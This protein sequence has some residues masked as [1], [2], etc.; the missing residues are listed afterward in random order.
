MTSY[1]KQAS[2]EC[3]QYA[4]LNENHL[5]SRNKMIQ[6]VCEIVFQTLCVDWW[7]GQ[8]QKLRW[9]ADEYVSEA[10]SVPPYYDARRFNHQE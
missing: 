1:N 2:K 10:G 9:P 3:L 4:Y 8:A 7:R 5:K 6:K